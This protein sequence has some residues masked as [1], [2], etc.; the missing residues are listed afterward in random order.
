MKDYVNN[1]QWLS[2]TISSLHATKESLE[3]EALVLSNR[4]KEIDLKIATYEQLLQKAN[5]K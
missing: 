3:G 4:I 2:E 5:Q 1:P